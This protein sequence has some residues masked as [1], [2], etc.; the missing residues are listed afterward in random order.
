[1]LSAFGIS[2]VVD[3]GTGVYMVFFEKP[4]KNRNYVILG[5]PGYP[6]YQVHFAGAPDV[7][8]AEPYPDHCTIVT[9]N[10]A[11]S[12]TDA[13]FAAAFFGELADEV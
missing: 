3:V 12:N 13:E 7:D 10:S 9:S 11:G 5:Q 4:F 6:A 2:S 1:M 8:W